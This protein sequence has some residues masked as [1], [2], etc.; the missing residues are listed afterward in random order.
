M[1]ALHCSGLQKSSMVMTGGSR[2]CT[3][4]PGVSAVAEQ[5]WE[6]VSLIG[7][8]GSEVGFNPPRLGQAHACR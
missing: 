7:A 1:M 8:R 6:V 2:Q 3:L 5:W 4:S